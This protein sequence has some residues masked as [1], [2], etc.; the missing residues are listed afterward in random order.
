[1]TLVQIYLDIGL[2]LHPGLDRHPEQKLS[3]F[4]INMMIR[5]AANVTWEEAVSA[6]YMDRQFLGV[7]RPLQ[8]SLSV[9]SKLADR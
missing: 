7:K 3:K 2:H 8:I 6:A 5:E 1:M 4:T 9:L